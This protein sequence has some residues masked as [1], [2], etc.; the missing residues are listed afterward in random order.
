MSE[1]DQQLIGALPHNVEP[2]ANYMNYGD[3]DQIEL[4]SERDWVA[5]QEPHVI[6]A[7][8]A[9]CISRAGEFARIAQYCQD[10]LVELGEIPKQRTRPLDFTKRAAVFETAEGS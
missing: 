9:Y 2:L 6:R 7:L 5:E 4:H 8:G 10:E 1:R 3:G